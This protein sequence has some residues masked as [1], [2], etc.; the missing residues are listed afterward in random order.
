MATLLDK[1]RGLKALAWKN[2]TLLETLKHSQAF[3]N[4]HSETL[5]SKFF[6]QDGLEIARKKWKQ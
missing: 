1:K 2:M 4:Y 3:V 6:C 5:V